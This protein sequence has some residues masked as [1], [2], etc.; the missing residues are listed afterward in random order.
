MGLS[1]VLLN[2]FVVLSISILTSQALQGGW[3]DKNM[4]DKGRDTGGNQG[5]GMKTECKVR[6]DLPIN[7][8][9]SNKFQM[10]G[11][12]VVDEN[13]RWNSY[14]VKI[15]QKIMNNRQ[16]AA[17]GNRNIQLKKNKFTG[18]CVPDSG[19]INCWILKCCSM[20]T[21]LTYVSYQRPICGQDWTLMK[22]IYLDI[23]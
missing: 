15:S 10:D 2:K 9:L 16:R 20:N 8:L 14:P 17:N 18:T 1:R 11:R 7:W 23:I 5:Y 3:M 21:S 22:W 19:K 13:W 12:T 4:R 6:H